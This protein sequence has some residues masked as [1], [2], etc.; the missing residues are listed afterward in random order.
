[1]ATDA[2]RRTRTGIA[3]VVRLTPRG[4]RD[5][6]DGWAAAADGQSVLKARVSVPPEDGR[7]NAALIALL[8][9]HLD[10]PKRA[11]RIAAGETSRTKTVEIDGDAEALMAR[12]KGV[13]L[14]K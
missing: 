9:A 14:A 3:V 10:V 5:A 11:V 4:G 8:A 12:L 6:I 13:G 1:M 2:A 7:A